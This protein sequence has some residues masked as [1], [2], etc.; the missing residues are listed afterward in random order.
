MFPPD[1]LALV[2]HPETPAPAVQAIE[3]RLARA[4]GGPIALTYRL[5]GDVARLRIPAPQFPAPADDLW[6]HTCFEFFIAVVGE[7]AYHEFNF[8]PS[9][10][11]AAY[12]FSGYRQRDHAVGTLLSAALAPQIVTR[13]SADR[14][15]LD[16]I[17]APGALLSCANGAPLQ[18]GF[19][20]VVEAADGS[21]SYWA[22]RHGTARP[23]FH[24]RE[25]FNLNLPD[26]RSIV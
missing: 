10:Q 15:E 7:A 4:P 20:T 21:R 23:D 11:W 26:P 19:A 2:C 18:T 9:G 25:T 24:Q 3:V 5:R 17:I 13:R 1:T 14:L 16:A 6:E 22:L 12:A 8:S